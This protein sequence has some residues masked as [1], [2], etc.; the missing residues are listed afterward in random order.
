MA[1]LGVATDMSGSQAAESMAQFAN[2][3]G[4]ANNDFRRLGSTV[5]A[6]GNNFVTGESK[7][8]DMAQRL[9]AAGKAVGMTEA[10]ILGLSAALSSLGLE[11]DAGGS[12]IS[13]ILMEIETLVGK[14]E[15]FE[16]FA[17]AAEMSADKFKEAWDEDATGT[18][19][20]FLEKLGQSPNIAG[21]LSELGINPSAFWTA[22]W[23]HQMQPG[24][25]VLRYR[26]N[27]PPKRTQQRPK[28]RLPKTILLR[29]DG[30]SANRFC[31]LLKTGRS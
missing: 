20:T 6:L 12:A 28:C 31:R 4:M 17:E 22:Q 29:P 3:T 5:V 11:P 15:G 21:V 13:T 16:V 23:K 18:F 19:L 1:E 27:T 30:L 8:M 24:R 25:R 7:I 26:P 14:G 9:G 10:D 2:L